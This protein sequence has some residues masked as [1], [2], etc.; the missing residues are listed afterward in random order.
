[1]SDPNANA[2]SDRPTTIEPIPHPPERLLFGN[3]LDI[4]SSTQV[5]DLIRLARGYGPIFSLTLAG[6]RLVVVWSQ[7]L[8]SEVCDERRFDKRV[9]AP[10]RR[11]RAFAGD[12]LFTAH[13]FEP[14]WSKAHHILL[15][16]FSGAAMKRYH[17][18]MLD[19]IHQLLDRWARLN[20]NDEV[21][22]SDAMT[23]LTLDTIG[24]CGFDYRFNSFFRERM[25]PFI[26]AMTRA[27][28]IALDRSI[29]PEIS[30]RLQWRQN[31]RFERS[32]ELMNQTVDGIIRERRQSG[33][34]PSVGNDLLSSMLS[35]VDR[36]TGEPLDDLNIRYQIITF[37]IAG[38]ETTSGLLSFATY[39]LVTHPEALER[40]TEEV[41]RVLGRDPSVDPSY[42]QVGELRYVR[43]V[44]DESL[45]LWPTA[46]MFALYP[47]EGETTLGGRY[48]ITK[49]DGLAVLI[50]MLH[51]DPAVWGEDP[52]AFDPDR[53]A[54]EREQSRPANAFKPFG[55]GQR[56]CIGRQFAMHEATLALAMI[57]QRFRLIAPPDYQLT[58][59][60]T[61]TLKPAGFKIRLETREH[62]EPGILLRRTAPP[63]AAVTARAPEARRQAAAPITETHGTP[64]LVLYGSNMG[65][66]EAAAQR[67]ADDGR[68]RGFAV[69][70]AALDDCTERLPTAGGVVIV[71]SSYNGSPPDN[72]TRFCVWLDQEQDSKRLADVHYSVFGCGHRDWAATYQAVPMRIDRRLAELG[73]VRVCARGA[74]DGGGDF[75]GD[76]ESWY[77]PLWDSL[78]RELGVEL[79]PPADRDPGFEVEMVAT[80]QPNP[81]VI[82]L[83]A[84]PMV[85][86]ENRELQSPAAGRSTRHIELALPPGVGYQTGD[87]L[88]VVGHNDEALVR[89]FARHFG[90]DEHSRVILRARGH[91]QSELPTG[92]PIAVFQLLAE[93]L[94][95]QDPATRA[96]IKAVAAAVECPPER[97]RLMA[98]A[99]DDDQGRRRYRAEILDRRVSLI[100]LLEDYPACR[101]P[102]GVA[103]GL[104]PP[105]RPRYYSISTSPRRYRNICG[106]TVAV[107]EGSA[108][109]GHGTFRGL[110]SSHLAGKE[111]GST[112]HAFVRDTHTAFR[113]PSDPR[114][115]LILVGPGTGLA[116]FRGFLQERAEL[117][118]ASREIGPTT[119]FFGCRHP[120][121]DFLYHDE[122]EAFAKDG[123]VELHVAF[124]RLDPERKVYVQHRILEQHEEVWRRL[125][126]GAIIYVC[127]DASRMAPAVRQA[128]AQIH[129]DHS[130]GDLASA[131]AWLDE[132]SR[133]GR[134]LVDVWASN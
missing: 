47:K 95:L 59:N 42:R 132:L 40:A 71:S 122:L 52:E 113:L 131:E 85:V 115:P 103:L 22:T 41:D 82:S 36:E 121:H 55:N 17:P 96:Q 91:A 12:G 10:L 100:D 50:P 102:F 106:I 2:S 9:W 104:L 31:K 70:V 19:V 133:S 48:R 88:G 53:F 1:M 109:S 111:K 51:R 84:Q 77:Q 79:T 43:Q 119:L 126:A 78:A 110:C 35:G 117:A 3:A 18:M 97:Q 125:A 66:A 94:E 93:Y 69:E 13:T 107:L 123:I 8:V 27:M 67:I 24:L 45:R 98:L 75:D 89:R 105:I 128:F 49:E 25:H 29:R 11:V 54:P 73:A 72:A 56:A 39:F 23:R 33:A 130:G 127:G 6:R 20:A 64:L 81:F 61:L 118:R 87:H 108:R 101:L 58:I 34:D 26:R 90:F 4:G 44:L 129:R 30:N 15:P 62:L 21:D 92:Q 14:N 76:F 32:V 112:V 38:H 65:T 116:P 63:V 68:G 60:E 7:E 120:D 86:V 134:Y 46:P 5:Q 16:S 28:S 124:S 99:T 74:G 80:E 57:L 114:L 37:L 83:G